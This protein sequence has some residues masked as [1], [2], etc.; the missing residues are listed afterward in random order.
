MAFWSA[1]AAIVVTALTV[2]P[3]IIR[4]LKSGKKARKKK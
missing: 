3:K 4:A 1:I 2:A